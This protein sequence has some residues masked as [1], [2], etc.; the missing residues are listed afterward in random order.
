MA[1]IF[2]SYA[3]NLEDVMLWRALRHV[4]PGFYVDVGA[5]SPT[6][7]SVTMALYGRGWHGINV[8]PDPRAFAE[9]ERARPRDINLEVALD[10]Q[11]G[12][13][14]ILLADH[15]ALSTMDLAQGDRLAHQGM[16]L[17]SHDVRVTTL[18][19]IWS[20]HV[21]QSQAVHFLKIDVEGLERRVLLGN[22]WIANR[23]WIVLVEATHP[24][25]PSPSH[26]DWVSILIE[27]RYR[28]AYFDGLNRYYVAEEHADL[29]QSF[30]RPPNVFDAY[31]R[32]SERE[33]L[34]RADE[35]ER[36]L[37]HLRSTRS[38]RWTEPIR[39]LKGKVRPRW[40][41]TRRR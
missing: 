36:E 8:E 15:A 1:A 25:T 38:W 31:V 13:L 37:T 35:L 41:G 24:Q 10:E 2:V 9:L 20:E 22:D 33:A 27:A 34:V 11:E 5:A 19:A 18:A 40:P 14:T 12:Q 6:I 17:T 28:D 32:A 4:G 23:P 7:D 3:Q 39:R 21:P 26:Y 29:L 16:D 30:D